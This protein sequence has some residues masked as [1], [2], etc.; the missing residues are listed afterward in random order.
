MVGKV[1]LFGAGALGRGYVGPAVWQAGYQLLLVDK[2]PDLVARL[3]AEGGYTLRLQRLPPAQGERELWLS[4]Y[5]AFFYLERQAIAAEMVQADLVLTAVFGEN[6][7][8]VAETIALGVQACRAAGRERPLNCIACENMVGNSSTLGKHVQA[9]LRGA[10]LEYCQATFGFPDCMVGRVVPRPEPDTLLIVTEDYDE[11]TVT[12]ADFKGAR[13]P[14]L[15]CFELV[16][17]LPARLERKLYIV[18]GGHAICAYL[19]LAAGH[20][21]VHEA[22]ADPAIQAVVAGALEESGAALDRKYGLGRERVRAYQQ[23][24]LRRAAMPAM[25]DPVERVVRDPLRKLAPQDRLL[26]PAR[27]AEGYGLP[28]ANLVRGIVAALAYR[29]PADAQSQR[30]A[31]MLQTLGPGGVLQQVCGLVPGSALY[32]EILRAWGR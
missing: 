20:T 9:R 15:D 16:E 22:I 26:G 3:R 5:R 10:D 30:L 12:A 19:G 7:P 25:R 14:G 18:N 2:K 27:L 11:W 21:F 32:Q 31:E 24:F 8:D 13:P 6:L 1:I 17:N 4:N 29:S 28:R 23:D